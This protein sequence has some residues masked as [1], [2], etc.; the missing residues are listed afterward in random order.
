MSAVKRHGEL[1]ELAGEKRVAA[2]QLPAVGAPIHD[3]FL[4]ALPPAHG[5]RVAVIDETAGALPPVPL[6]AVA[7]QVP[8]GTRFLIELP[9]VG[10]P[11]VL[12]AAIHHAGHPQHD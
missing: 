4:E 10:D 7:R 8:F 1:P 2:I 12:A 6:V 3:L 11:N 5:V 9:R